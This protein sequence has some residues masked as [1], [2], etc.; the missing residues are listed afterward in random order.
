MSFQNFYQDAYADL[1]RGHG[2]DPVA[3]PTFTL[4]VGAA[5][6]VVGAVAPQLTVVTCPCDTN[7]GPAILL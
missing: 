1:E 3:E 7:G 6:R 5:L 4:R 2:Y